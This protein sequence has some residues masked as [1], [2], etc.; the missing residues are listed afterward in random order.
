M[1]SRLAVAWP[2]ISTLVRS[3]G[4]E[5]I[6]LRGNEAAAGLLGWP[7]A[8]AL[9]RADEEA[10]WAAPMEEELRPDWLAA[11]LVVGTCTISDAGGLDRPS[12]GEGVR[13]IE[14]GSMVVE[15]RAEG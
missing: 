4:G 14:M 13:G 9:P 3:S 10:F 6:A 2:L 15:R 8:P 11:A 1:V 7:L 12:G 5:C